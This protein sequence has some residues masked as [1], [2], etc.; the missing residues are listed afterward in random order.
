MK[1]VRNHHQNIIE[2]LEQSG[3]QEASEQNKR[4]D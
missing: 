1:I 4:L 3:S 2:Y